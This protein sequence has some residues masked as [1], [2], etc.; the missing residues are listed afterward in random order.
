MNNVGYVYQGILKENELRM[1][2]QYL[3]ENTIY[4]TWNL[5]SIKIDVGQPDELCE[6]GILFNN[7]CEIRWQH[8]GKK[9]QVLLPCDKEIKEDLPLNKLNGEWKTKDEEIRLIQLN[10]S[11]FNPPFERYPIVNVP[12]AKIRCK[13]FYY[14][15]FAIFISPREVIEDV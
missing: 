4:I 2:F 6:H 14:N 11:K 9:F 10:L 5:K 8:L 1:I 3:G 7:W 13:I 12:K 15:N